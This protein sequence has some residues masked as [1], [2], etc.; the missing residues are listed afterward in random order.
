MSFEHLLDTGAAEHLKYGENKKTL[1]LS[2][3]GLQ[4]HLVDKKYPNKK[5]QYTL[6]SWKVGEVY[7]VEAYDH[8]QDSFFGKH[9]LKEENQPLEVKAIG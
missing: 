2:W 8:L 5:V 1:P 7:L 9:K 3:R 4:P 6:W